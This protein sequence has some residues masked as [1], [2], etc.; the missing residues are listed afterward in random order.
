[1]QYQIARETSVGED[2]KLKALETKTSFYELHS[3]WTSNFSTFT[4]YGRRF[5]DPSLGLE[6]WF[7]GKAG[8]SFLSQSRCWGLKFLWKKDFEE[9]SSQGTYVLNL[10]VHFLNYEREFGNLTSR[11]NTL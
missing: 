10:V 5:K 8:F 6:P 1:L 9:L 3:G 2:Q 4:G 11:F 7:A